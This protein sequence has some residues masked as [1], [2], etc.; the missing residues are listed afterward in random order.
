MDSMVN[1]YTAAKRL[2][3]DDAYTPGGKAGMRLHAILTDADHFDT[4]VLK[5][6]VKTSKR[7]GLTG[8]SGRVVFRVKV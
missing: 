8:A 7:A 2:R 1:H 3:S 5:F 6:A 4:F